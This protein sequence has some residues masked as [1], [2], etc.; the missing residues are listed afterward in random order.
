M[1]AY[2]YPPEGSSSGVQRTFTF[3][4]YLRDCGW[5]PI[6]L[7]AHPR[8][9]GVIRTEQLADIPAGVVVRRAFALDTG[10]HLAVRGR[11]PRFAAL[12]DRWSSW[13]FGAVAAGWK[14]VREQR[15][16]VLWSTYPIATAHLI[17]WALHRITGLP[18]VADFRDSM[19][20]ASYP[21][22]ETQRNVYRWIERRTLSECVRGVFTTPGAIRMYRDR[23]PDL[24][25]HRL[26]LIENGFDE[27]S[28]GKALDVPSVMTK[29]SARQ[30]VLLHSGILYPEERDPTCFYD[31][32][33]RLQHRSVV[34]H[35][36]LRIVL[37]G[38]G[39][40]DFHGRL[41]RERG[42]EQVVTLLP[43][44]AYR[45]ALK[46]MTEADG[47]LIL[48]GTS[49]NHQIPA[50]VYE[51]LRA[52]RPVLALT[53]PQGDTAEL[54]K[55]AGASFIAPLDDVNAIENAL[56]RF[57]LAIRAGTVNVMSRSA[58]LAYSRR[59]RTQEFAKL[60]NEITSSG[61]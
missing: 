46:E 24:P 41:I 56:E 58:A 7:T 51:Y 13:W 31:A 17:G 9:Y 55:K 11:Y 5:E 39:H 37:R 42:I 33:A 40:D 25:S 49:C 10:R 1:I 14:L 50:K 27:E 48:Q 28:F 6:V 34:S 22:D 44:I 16:R 53:D 32:V 38:T 57:L 3:S 4:R 36:T 54:L 45:E 30:T 60:L 2:H 47:L 35:E 43:S 20:E 29:R 59:A 8:A 61:K 26:V 21:R 18:W 12:P 15:P 52:G 19:T 23:Y